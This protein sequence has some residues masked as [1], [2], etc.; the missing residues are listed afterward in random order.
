MVLLYN[1]AEKFIHWKLIDVSAT[2]WKLKVFQYI[3][4]MKFLVTI[5]YCIKLP[6]QNTRY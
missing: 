2:G 1:C 5:E 4:T 6:G 3:S